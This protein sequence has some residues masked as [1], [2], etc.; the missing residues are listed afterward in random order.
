MLNSKISIGI[1]DDHAIVRDGLAMIL[2]LE[3]DFNVVWQAE[4][5]LQAMALLSKQP[6]HVLILDLNMPRLS[7]LEIVTA[8][9]ASKGL[10]KIILLT[11]SID[12]HEVA[13]VLR[14]GADGYVPKA[15]G[16]NQIVEAI[17]FVAEGEGDTYIGQGVV[18]PMHNELQNTREHIASLTSREREI[19]GLIGNGASTKAIAKTLG[20]SDGTVRKHRENLTGKL[21]LHTPAET[22]ALAIRY[23]LKS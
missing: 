5:G 14:A 17:R 19:F 1:A 16:A 9:R 23:R 2:S 10:S 7:G 22:V 15:N 21:G 4:D 6:P 18:Q 13:S 12:E 3:P 11:G 8:Y 20:I